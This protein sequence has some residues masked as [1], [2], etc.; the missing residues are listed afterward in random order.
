MGLFDKLFGKKAPKIILVH[1]LHPDYGYVQQSW[2]VGKDISADV[3]KR[4]AK[5]N[6]LYVMYVFKNREENK[7]ILAKESFL[8]AVTEYRQIDEDIKEQ[9]ERALKEFDLK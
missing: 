8:K 5:D 3:V 9:Q 4:R 6:E 1:V 7:L 2:E